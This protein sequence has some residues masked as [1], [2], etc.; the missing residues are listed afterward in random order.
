MLHF[1]PKKSV[2]WVVSLLLFFPTLPTWCQTYFD[3]LRIGWDFSSQKY[4]NAGVYAR[5]KKLPDGKLAMVY[6][7]GSD[8]YFVTSSDG[9]YKWSNLRQVS[10]DSKNVYNYTNSELIVLQNGK[11]MYAWNAR[12]ND[13]SNPGGPYKIMAKYSAN[14][15]LTWTGEQTLFTAS[16]TSNEGCWEPAM[17]Q[18]PSGE[19]QLYFANEYLVTND[20]QN[21]S[22]MRSSDNG[23]T[24]GNVEVVSFRSGSRDGMPVPLVLQN[25]KDLV[26]AIE[27]NG[28]SGTFKP[29]I[30][31]TT[32]ADNWASGTVSGSSTNRWAALSSYETLASSIYAGAPYLIQLSSGETLLSVQSG[33]DRQTP[34]SLD[35]ALMQVY[36]GSATARGFLSK[37]TPF[38]FVDNESASVLWNSLCQINDSTVMA[39]SS[40]SGLS[41]NEGIWT[42][43]GRLMK[44][45]QSMELKSGAEKWTTDTSSVFL[46]ACSQAQTNV[47]SMWDADSLYFR[48]DV[49]DRLVKEAAAG[50]AVWDTD[51]IEIY[52]NPLKKM[53]SSIAT[54]MYKVL[55]NVAGVSACSYSASG[56][57]KDWSPH[58][59]F[60]VTRGVSK[61]YTVYV[62]LPWN[63]IGGKPVAN[64][65]VAMF[66]LHNN[67]G[68]STIVHENLSGANPDKPLTWMRVKMVATSETGI[69]A[70][71][72][73]SWQLVAPSKVH[74]HQDF[75]ISLQNGSLSQSKI[76]VYD[77]TSGILLAACESH[78]S[79]CLIPGLNA[80][81]LVVITV[82]LPDNRILSKKIMVK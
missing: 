32:L 7:A 21:I 42:V 62:S 50:G 17:V 40:I 12:P 33:E 76:R 9:G 19:L 26:L 31:H 8:V 57:W 49:N 56:V 68:T 66:K 74:A 23:A 70:T 58:L 5:V 46:G 65:F 60:T 45:L 34:G 18:L 61:N 47:K 10:H 52:L 22:M 78:S 13:E 79:Q 27:D 37:S 81:G 51:G 39:V 53:T 35:H 72:S 69:S 38:P 36:V 28:L 43:R 1:I 29:V 48:F 3:G 80:C 14:N 15:G 75:S 54:G 2:L 24:W 71:Q 55:V 30:I 11:L 73:G 82:E 25:E 77:G 67:D 4:V 6:S 59:H 20:N 41:A 64:D 44:P 63:E 16:T